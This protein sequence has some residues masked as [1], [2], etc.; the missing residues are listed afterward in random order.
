MSK[1]VY[2]IK[3]Y[4]YN[5]YEE[6]LYNYI[7]KIKKCKDIISIYKFGDISYPGLSD[8]DILIVLEDKVLEF[9]YKKYSAIRYK[10]KEKYIFLHEPFII[11][12]SLAEKAEILYPLTNLSHLEGEKIKFIKPNL[13]HTTHFFIHEFLNGYMYWWKR[14]RRRN[15][16]SLR[17]IIPQFTSFT[18]SFRIFENIISKF[19]KNDNKKEYIDLLHFLK[20]NIF[21]MNEYKINLIINRLF[22]LSE[23]LQREMYK[24]TKLFIKN[25]LCYVSN[26]NLYFGYL[27][28]IVIFGDF[29]K[30]DERF[31]FRRLA[32]EFSIIID[33]KFYSY[34]QNQ[35]YRRYFHERL[36]IIKYYEKF[37]FDNNL[38]KFTKLSMFHTKMGWKLNNIFKT[39]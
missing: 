37:I 26:K 27:P 36:K 35:K 12:R 29:E 6:V 10:E 34:N 24:A 15:K 13:Y 25:K 9:N 8:I 22:T 11:N 1:L 16:L 4:K 14:A 20:E 18:H 32:N 21:N 23:I 28:Y 33:P 17:N 39:F 30:G 5:D 3:Q 2:D 19:Y 38:N 31:I 7:K